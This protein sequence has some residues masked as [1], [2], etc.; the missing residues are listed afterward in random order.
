MIIIELD[1][2]DSTNNYAAKLKPQPELPFI[3]RANFQNKGRGQGNNKWESE[4]DKNLLFS[5]VFEPKHI[6]AGKNFFVSKFIALRLLDLIR[7]YEVSAVIKWP[8]DILVQ[9]KKLAGILIENTISGNQIKRCI[10]GVGLN[11]NQ[12]FSFENLNAVSMNELT[13][14]HFDI[15][16][17]FYEFIEIFKTKEFQ[18]KE[19]YLQQINQD[20][21]RNLYK[22]NQTGLFKNQQGQFAARI[23]D[24]Q[25]DGQI[26][27]ENQKGELEKFSF[28]EIE[29]LLAE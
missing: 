2:T 25:D 15:S 21:F 27:L 11:I 1:R 18:L 5:I 20:Y 17:L 29:F 3:V 16:A 6:P 9:G 24:V 13:G 8:N 28:G 19:E 22:F 26:V 4:K 23:C 14:K 12:G 7:I 10:A